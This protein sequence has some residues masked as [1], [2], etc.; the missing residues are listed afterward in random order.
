MHTLTS[1]FF[2][3][4]E[5]FAAQIGDMFSLL[6]LCSLA[7]VSLLFWRWWCRLAQSWWKHR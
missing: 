7:T 4:L 2:A 6:L 3:L 5:P 1:M